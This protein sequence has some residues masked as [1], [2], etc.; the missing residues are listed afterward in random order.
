MNKKIVDL[1]KIKEPWSKDDIKDAYFTDFQKTLS[2]IEST[3]GGK[4]WSKIENIN[5]IFTIFNLCKYDLFKT[6]ED[7]ADAY[8]NASSKKEF[9]EI[10]EEKYTY[11]IKKHILC[12]SAAASSFANHAMKLIKKSFVN[13]YSNKIKS[14]FIDDGLSKFLIDFMN[15]MF[16]EKIVEI[17]R[18]IRWDKNGENLIWLIS[19][20]ELLE[21]KKW[22]KKSKDFIN[23]SQGK[24]DICKVFQAY[25]DKLAKFY[26]WYEKEAK[27]YY[28]EI[29][30]PYFLYEKYLKEIENSFSLEK[31]IHKK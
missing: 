12:T 18:N 16:Y 10:E 5:V 13:E 3:E 17:G 14:E 23:D 29:L 1:K 7:F 26:K 22:N 11:L 21:Y 30:N 15:I 27:S 6:I 19:S 8:S 31:A 9:L 25:N 20:E 28:A 2:V 24:I 4:L